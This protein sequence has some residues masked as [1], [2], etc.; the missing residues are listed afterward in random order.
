[1]KTTQG[2]LSNGNGDNSVGFNGLPAGY[3]NTNTGNPAD[4]AWKTDLGN[5]GLWWSA[6]RSSVGSAAIANRWFV[7]YANRVL[8]YSADWTD[9]Y[10]FNVRCV[11]K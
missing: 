6:T 7:S 10:Y 3:Y 9:Y 2:W 1:M 4:G 8:T 5:C 11:K